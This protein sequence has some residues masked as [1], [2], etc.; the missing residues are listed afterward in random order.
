[1]HAHGVQVLDRADDHHVVVMIAHH[2]ELEFL[3]PQHAALDQH[4]RR[5][6]LV[7]AATH[8]LLELLAVVRDAASG[9]AEREGRADDRRISCALDD[10]FG[11]VEGRGDTAFGDPQADPLHRFSEELSILGDR[12]R[13]RARPDQLDAESLERA[14]LRQGHRHIERGLAS[15]RRQQR[16]RALLLDDQLDELGRH[17]LDVR[18]VR[19]L[20]IR[21]DRRRIGVHEDDLEP[22]LAKRLG[23]LRSGVVEL[24]GLA[25]DDRPGSDDENAMQVSAARHESDRR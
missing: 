5:R 1:M 10:G 19:D 21:H 24:R 7:Q 6:R 16:V 23:R 8:D 25:D 2:L 15:H 17:G 18:A 3:P 22:L 14:R 9:A 11:L 4:L 13:V 20:G 12:D